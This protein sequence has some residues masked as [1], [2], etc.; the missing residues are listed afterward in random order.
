M[1]LTT[2]F[3]HTEME[4]LPYWTKRG[5]THNEFAVAV[6]K[7]S[8]T[9]IL[10]YLHSCQW[11]PTASNRPEQFSESSCSGWCQWCSSSSLQ[12]LME[13]TRTLTDVSEQLYVPLSTVLDN[14]QCYVAQWFD[15][16][17]ENHRYT[18]LLQFTLASSIVT[19]AENK[20]VGITSHLWELRS[21]ER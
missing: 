17:V 4:E 15:P 2:W 9:S 13:Q 5:N 18:Q 11:G 8:R 6:E 21:S 19:I 12:Q 1:C 16:F 14:S 3:Q 7:D 10:Q 20:T